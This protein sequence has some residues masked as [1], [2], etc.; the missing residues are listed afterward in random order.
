MTRGLRGVAS[1]CLGTGLL[2]IACNP[3]NTNLADRTSIGSTAQA[4][5]GDSQRFMGSQLGSKQLILTFDDGPNT[6]AVTGGLS[7]WLKSRPV[8]IRAT[9]FVNGACIADTSLPNDSC[10]SPTPDAVT[11]MKQ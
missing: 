5:V 3:S 1:A 4:L 11:T 6:N 2:L 10:G 7:T 9:F 8:P